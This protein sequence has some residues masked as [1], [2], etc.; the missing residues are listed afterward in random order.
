MS[1]IRSKAATMILA[2]IGAGLMAMLAAFMA[3]LAMAATI[4]QARANAVPAQPAATRCSAPRSLIDP[5]AHGLP[6]Q[7]G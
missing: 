3:G 2:G 5:G 6:S 4:P 7:L 1:S